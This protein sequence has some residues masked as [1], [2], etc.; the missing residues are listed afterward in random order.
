MAYALLRALAGIALRWY[1]RDI[2]VSGSDRIP[3]H[4]PLLLAVNHPNA[5]VD[6][7]L[8]GWIMPRRVLIT[9]K[10]TIFKNPVGAILLRW[11]G[12][13]PLRRASDEAAAGASISAAR[14]AETFRAVQNA[15]ATGRCILIF[16]EGKTPEEPSLAPLKTGAAR[17]ALHAR[18]SG[19]SN[20]AIL[21][22]GLVFERK[23]RPRSRVFVEIGEP[24]LVDQWRADSARSASDA[25]TV[26]IE[27]RLRALTLSYPDADAATRATKLAMALASVVEPIDRIGEVRGFAVEADIAHRVDTLADYLASAGG[28]MRS[29]AEFLVERLHAVEATARER[30][31]A[32]DD[33]RIELGHSSALRFILR[34][35]WYLLVG[36][37]IALWGRMN[38]WL[39]FRAARLLAMRNVESASDPAMRT[40]VAGAALVLVAYLAQTLLVVWLWGLGVGL[41]YLLSLPIAA[42][43]NFR[44]TDRLRRA[45]RRARAYLVMRRDQAL[46]NEL[47]AELARLRD[48]ILVFDEDASAAMRAERVAQ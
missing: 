16:P 14:N 26:E 13:L 38:H 1:Y 9:A 3:R 28:A 36:G 2:Q 17:M 42:D 11:L 46:R 24:I 12:V 15:L 25:L 30:G 27:S 31:I 35:G 33:A 47:A 40:I 18:D 23:E 10:A 45:V 34:E 4:G 21:P 6:A 48:D 41:L 19:V 32:L 8:V 5:L 20:L 37:P 22:I 43:V 29:R 39:P 44:L 7:L